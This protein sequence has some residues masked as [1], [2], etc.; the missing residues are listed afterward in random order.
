MDR[1]RLKTTM[2][3]GLLVLCG[4]AV[5]GRQARQAPIE[6]IDERG[7]SARSLTA[8]AGSVIRFIN[9][10]ARPHQIYSNDCAELSS[11]LLQPGEEYAAML[12]RGP[13]L[14]HFQDLLA[15]LVTGYAGTVDVHD[16]HEERRVAAD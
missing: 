10:D 6:K 2:V 8:E 11:T 12:G 5:L 9:A 16:E 13:K 4:C 7:I 1:R 15:P 14:C 3:S